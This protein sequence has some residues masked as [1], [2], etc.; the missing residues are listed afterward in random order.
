MSQE[1]CMKVYELL[2]R[3]YGPRHWWPAET[4]FEVVVGA[5]LTQNV[6]WKNVEKAISALKAIE[7]LSPEAMTA[8]PE[9][10]LAEKIRP[11]G[12]YH[13]KARKLK[14]FMAF[15]NTHYRGS[16]ETMFKTPLPELRKELLGVFGIGPETADSILLYAGGMPTFVVDTYTKRIFSRLGWM[17][18]SETYDRVQRF[19][20]DAI[21]PSTTLYNEYHALIVALG[22]TCCGNKKTKCQICP[23]LSVCPTGNTIYRINISGCMLVKNM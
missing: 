10:T 19:F 6:S 17:D 2:Y 7:A 18:P 23:L 3:A 4:P 8:L 22:S 16:L 13:S 1:K 21:L 20:M 5:I 15:L 11:T 9:D 12:Y 14:A